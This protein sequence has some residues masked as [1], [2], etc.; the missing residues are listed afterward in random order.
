MAYNSSSASSYL[1]LDSLA[2]GSKYGLE[3][4][5]HISKRTGGAFVLKKPTLYSCLTRMEKKGLVS[6]S[7]WGDSELGGKRHYYTIT[8]DG[9]REYAQLSLEFQ[10]A[11]F[12][13]EEEE[14]EPKDDA[15]F[16]EERIS[17]PTIMQQDNIFNLVNGQQTT[18]KEE[19]RSEKKQENNVVENQMDIFSLPVEEKVEEQENVS[20]NETYQS[21]TSTQNNSETNSQTNSQYTTNLFGDRTVAAQERMDFN[22]T[23]LQEEEKR[24]DAVLL[25]D[26]ERLT[27]EEKDENQRIFDTS[28]ELKK[29]RKRKSFAENQIEMDVVYETEQDQ[30]IQRARIE[31]LKASLL[32]ARNKG[33]SSQ[34]PPKERSNFAYQPTFENPQP[35]AQPMQ[36]TAPQQ[37]QQEEIIS[38][39]QPDDDAVFI[40]S[41][42]DE[43]PVQKKITPPDIEISV[44][45][46]NLPAP[47]RNSNLE[48]T[49]KD[50]MSKLFERKK[51]KEQEQQQ[52]KS[53]KPAQKQSPAA[54]AK[55]ETENCA[56][57]DS[58]V[59][60]S[61]L[62]KY[63]NGHGIEFKE[64]QS[65]KV[66][67]NHNTNFLLFISSIVLLFLSGV[68]AAVIYGIAYAT[69]FLNPTTNFMFYTIPILFFLYTIFTLVRL[70]WFASKKATLLYNSVVNWAIFVLSIVIVVI[71]NIICGMQY[72]NMLPY[73][74]SL[75]LP[76]YAMLLCFPLN[77]YIK[78]FLYRHFSR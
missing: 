16:V 42:Y 20:Q 60:Y 58:F 18:A 1:I 22:Q 53:A 12:T 21:Q 11:N 3:I 50:M 15:V 7:Y 26:D 51:E 66:E 23:N 69:K 28:S 64:Y 30:E 19:E 4:I 71:V 24:D 46:E 27:T 54:A 62:K 2:D 52:E 13:S 37:H 78:K 5:E 48:P 36:Q 40:T 70:K 17:T 14:E 6:S 25:A 49:Y 67:R 73:I 41:R 59:D 8:T 38:Q 57:V 56:K 39:V 55:V 34:E 44:T 29:F 61:T 76:I 31:E 75:V 65:S 33:F 32:S 63:Y 68:G 35:A 9:K 10:N 77:Y 72:E 47:K 43:V 74:T 45:T